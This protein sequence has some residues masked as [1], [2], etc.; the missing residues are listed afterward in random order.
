VPQ[1]PGEGPNAHRHGGGDL[2][3]WGFQTAGRNR[4]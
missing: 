3:V 1:R 2:L 4:Q